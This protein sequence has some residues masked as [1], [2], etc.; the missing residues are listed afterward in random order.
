MGAHQGAARIVGT[1][2]HI[3]HGKTALVLA[4]TGRSTDRLPEERARGISIDLGF[5]PLDLGP[6]GPPASIVDVPGHESFIRNMVAGASGMDAVLFTVAADEGLMPQS[7]EHLLVLQALGVDRGVVAVTKADLV[8]PAWAELVVETIRETLNVTPLAA[9]PVVVVSARSGV[10]IERLRAAL[11]SALGETAVRPTDF[12]FR[13]PVDRSFAIAGVGTVVTGTVWSGRVAEGE[14][15][16]ALPAAA[17]G[18]T[19]RPQTARVRSVEVHGERVAEAVAGHRAALALAGPAAAEVPRGTVL[20]APGVPWRPVVRIDAACWLARSARPLKLRDRVRV[21]HGTSEVMARVHGYGESLEPGGDGCAFLALEAPIVAAAGDRIVLRAYSPVTTIGGGTVLVRDARR[22]RSS[23]RDTRGKALSALAGAPPAERLRLALEIAGR[24]GIRSAA[25]PL[26][27]GLGERT[28]E[29]A[30]ARAATAIEVHGDRWFA[31]GAREGLAVRLVET[32]AAQH[33]RE[34][35]QSGL[36]LEA[37]RRALRP[38]APELVEAT[39]G[40]LLDSGRIE[41]RGPV[42]ALSGTSVEP[43][44][45]DRRLL[46]SLR[47]AYGAAGLE[48]PETEILAAALE[49]E[50]ARLRILQRH[51][52]SEGELVKLASDWYADAVALAAARAAI[53]EQLQRAGD[54]DTGALKQLLGVSR[55]YLIPILEHFDRSGITRREGNRRVLVGPRSCP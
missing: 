27:T 40:A 33:A 28:L 36:P 10:G 23:S 16:L 9:A 6:G 32:L 44:P 52:E 17:R 37:A 29:A 5:A 41:R 42:L 45:A 39:I 46:A 8:E 54:A 30:R 51:L 18:R 7:H 4:L 20:V 22:H 3:D 43:G 14:T 24:T 48:P 49:V 34:P 15:V 19:A 47:A 1:A 13:L 12:P 55:K 2:G 26:E 25:L 11:A 53:V 31:R 38:A 21:H 35:L 50:P